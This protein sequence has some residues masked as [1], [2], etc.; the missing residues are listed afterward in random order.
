MP[1]RSDVSPKPSAERRNSTDGPVRSS[2]RASALSTTS[3]NVTA[4][5]SPHTHTRNG[6]AAV[7]Y[8][9]SACSRTVARDE[10]GLVATTACD[11]DCVRTSASR[12]GADVHADNPTATVKATA[13]RRTRIA[14][15]RDRKAVDHETLD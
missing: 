8:L 1:C 14:L 12:D 2:R 4:T 15:L 11:G 9:R 10:M 5:E 6:S 13:W 7:P 3:W